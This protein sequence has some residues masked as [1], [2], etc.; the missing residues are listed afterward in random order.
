VV[1]ELAPLPR[2]QIGPF[3]LLGIEKDADAEQIESGWAER[4]KQARKQQIDI[5]LEDINWAREMLRDPEK[6]VRADAAS[7]NVDITEGVLR[8]LEQRFGGQDGETKW[9]P[10][11]WEKDLRH[12]TPAVEAPA[13]ESVRAAIVVPEPSREIPAVGR[14]VEDFARTALALD[15]WAIP[16]PRTEGEGLLPERSPEPAP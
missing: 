10:L 16:L 2:E 3:L 9:Q 6:R 14:L 5:A 1:L 12:Y 15:P 11:D 7:L 8:R 13:P 4:L